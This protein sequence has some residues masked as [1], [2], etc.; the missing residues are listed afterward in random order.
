LTRGVAATILVTMTRDLD[1]RQQSEGDRVRR[2]AYQREFWPAIGAYVLVTVTLSFWAGFEGP[3]PWRF[4]WA[5]LPVIPAAWVVR[6]V[7]RHVRRVD[8]YQKLLLLESLAVG[9]AVAMLA[10]I[11]LGFLGLAGFRPSWGPWVVYTA[12][13][14]G[15]A[16]TGSWRG[17]RCTTGSAN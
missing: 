4:L 8:E 9:F 16:V 12:G 10:A 1:S 3:S 2:R 11:S 7:L 13:M 6:A 15:W 5:L 14:L 17:R